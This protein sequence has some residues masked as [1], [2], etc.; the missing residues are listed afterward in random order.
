MEESSEVIDDCTSTDKPVGASK[1]L[2]CGREVP[3]YWYFSMKFTLLCHSFLFFP[4]VGRAW[5]V[6]PIPFASGHQQ[7]NS[8]H[9]RRRVTDS[10]IPHSTLLSVVVVVALSAR[11]GGK[12]YSTSTSMVVFK[13]APT[14]TSLYGQPSL[15]RSCSCFRRSAIYI[16][17]SSFKCYT[18]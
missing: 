15:L 14:S 2:E 9:R 3:Y 7:T 16:N 6:S 11:C 8:S 12:K 13:T 18:M 4:M 5:L 17:C 10:T 1:R